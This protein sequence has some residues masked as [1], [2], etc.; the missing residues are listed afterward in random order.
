[1]ERV[2]VVDP[3]LVT[4][5]YDVAFRRTLA[6]RIDHVSLVGRPLRTYKTLEGE[7]F[8]FSP[9]FYGHAE[10]SF[11]GWRTPRSRQL[12]KGLK[13][14]FGLCGL[15]DLVARD[16]PEIIHLPWFGLRFLDWYLLRLLA[17]KT[18]LV[19]T[20]HD[21][22]TFH[23]ASHASWLQTF[24]ERPGR[25]LFDHLIVHRERTRNAP[26]RSGA[27]A[28]TISVLAHPPQS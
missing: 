2:H 20:V 27:P 5:P 24:G 11:D 7:P 13:R 1:M 25:R 16:R 22:R 17:R 14:A 28:S 4:L 19:M 15:R 23:G 21:A 3:P 26:L 12:L 8:V 10:R 18:G 6:D 9:L